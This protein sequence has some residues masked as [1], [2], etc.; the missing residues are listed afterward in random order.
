MHG[1]DCYKQIVNPENLTEFVKEHSLLLYKISHSI[2]M[3]LPAHIELDDL[4]QSGLIGL[5]E[6][7]NNFSAEAGATFTTYAYIKIRFAIY[8]FLRKH[9]G[10][11]R[12]ISQN[13]KKI[14][15]AVAKIEHEGIS[16]VSTRTIANEMG[17]PIEQYCEI[18]REI[19]AYNTMS[20]TDS[21]HL[22]E[23]PCEKTQNPLNFIE[24][25]DVKSL[26]KS[27]ISTL[28]KREQLSLALYYNEQLNFKEI[29]EMVDLSEAR[30]SQIH[31]NLMIKLKQKITSI[32][33]AGSCIY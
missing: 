7:K 16:P 21:E 26:L 20:F 24:N 18:S 17:I 3:K 8:E 5:L 1:V 10:I 25:E 33:E 4:L 12:D 9:S 13:I 11:T 2:K 15:T 30:I 28:P 31:S 23:I 22:A 29:G 19:N 32:D 6:A 27:I 14:S